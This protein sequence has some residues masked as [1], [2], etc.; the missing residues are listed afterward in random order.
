M[1]LVRVAGTPVLGSNPSSWDCNDVEISRH[2]SLA[3]IILLPSSTS[4]TVTRQVSVHHGALG[5]AEDVVPLA[6]LLD[7]NLLVEK[8]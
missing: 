8:C 4:S 1:D 2:Y 7:S 5:R 3:I 6:A